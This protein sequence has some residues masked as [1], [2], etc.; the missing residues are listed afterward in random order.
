MEKSWF[1]RYLYYIT[2]LR[3][4]AEYIAGFLE[5]ERDPEFTQD[6]VGFA[7]T[8]FGLALITRAERG[9]DGGFARTLS[10]LI[11]E[12]RFDSEARRALDAFK[13]SFMKSHVIVTDLS[14]RDLLYSYDEGF[15]HRFFV[16][17]RYGHKSII[18]FTVIFKSSKLKNKR[19]R[20]V[21]AI[22][23]QTALREKD[24]QNQ[25]DGTR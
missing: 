20:L 25:H 2:Y 13:T 8:N 24:K 6:V 9:K 5:G 23:R 1:R 14:I 16:I 11:S 10:D 22:I 12:G 19:K 21:R 17:D 4:C 3:E 7:D 15:V 18:P